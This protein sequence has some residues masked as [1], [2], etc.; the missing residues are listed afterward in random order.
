MWAMYGEM[1]MDE[2]TVG[3]YGWSGT[4]CLCQP[5]P[6]QNGVV[7]SVCHYGK[8][9]ETINLLLNCMYMCVEIRYSKC[10][11]ADEYK[12]EQTGTRPSTSNGLDLQ[13]K[14][15]YICSRKTVDIKPTNC[16]QW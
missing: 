8:T 13:Q 12:K 15:D 16:C 5:L 1:N 9:V 10:V 14:I 6:T 2:Y 3:M 4:H 11:R 7:E